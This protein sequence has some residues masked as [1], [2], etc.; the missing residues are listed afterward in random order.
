EGYGYSW[1]GFRRYICPY[2]PGLAVEVNG[3]VN[4]QLP[5]IIFK[6]PTIL[7]TEGIESLYQIGFRY[8]DPTED[9]RIFING[10]EVLKTGTTRAGLIANFVSDITPLLP[11]GATITSDNESITITG[12][13][14]VTA[15][16]TRG[17]TGFE[18]ETTTNDEIEP[19]ATE[20]ATTYTIYFPGINAPY[21][22]D[23]DGTE[24]NLTVA[25]IQSKTS[26]LSTLLANLSAYEAEIVG[27]YVEVQNV[28]VV[29]K[30]SVRD[31]NDIVINPAVQA[32]SSTDKPWRGD[33]IRWDS[34][35][36]V[37]LNS[38][39]PLETSSTA[40]VSSNLK[41][42]R[43]NYSKQPYARLDPAKNPG[44]FITHDSDLLNLPQPGGLLDQ[45]F[46]ET[47]LIVEYGKAEGSWNEIE[48]QCN[49]VKPEWFAADR[50]KINII[51]IAPVVIDY[52]Q[53]SE[54]KDLAMGE[55]ND[56]VE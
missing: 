45:Y 50:E 32:T 56:E 17:L 3:A 8:V 40:N 18:V 11:T 5:G 25:N 35:P 13:V 10:T 44:L 23:I 21:S 37:G 27:N 26:A 46:T 39:S 24:V 52:L 54:V 41:Y 4:K 7:S 38:V 22:L 49:Q 28:Y 9:Y 47:P 31:Y 16:P 42:D 15:T 2:T 33:E 43:F 51:A 1:G 12:V 55:A 14:E 6:Y 34:T 53:A 29:E 30:I 19:G 20:S 36:T 48:L